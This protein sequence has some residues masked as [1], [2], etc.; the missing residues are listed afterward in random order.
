MKRYLLAAAVFISALAMAG[1]FWYGYN[2]N[3]GTPVTFIN[4]DGTPSL[5]V[6]Q[7][8]W[9][10]IWR[11]DLVYQRYY[12]Y[13]KNRIEESVLIVSRFPRGE[14]YAARALDPREEKVFYV[15]QN[16]VTML[17][18]DAGL[19]NDAWR[20][21][22]TQLLDEAKKAL[23]ADRRA[24]EFLKKQTAPPPGKQVAVNTRG[25]FLLA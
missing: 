16:E 21:A 2:R 12:D 11:G 17:D 14:I 7:K 19:K 23:D 3:F 8:Q 18:E 22:A 5:V 9:L 6:V 13:Q 24:E 15:I 20:D 10:A 4:T 1:F 25:S